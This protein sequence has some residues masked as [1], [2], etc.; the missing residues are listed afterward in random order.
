MNIQHFFH[1]SRT[2]RESAVTRRTIAFDDGVSRAR[3]WVVA[4]LLCLQFLAGCG[5]GSSSNGGDSTRPLFS[6]PPPP[7][8]VPTD[9]WQGGYYRGEATFADGQY[10]V[11]AIVTQQGELRMIVGSASDPAG[12]AQFVGWYQTSGDQADGEGVIIGQGCAGPNPSP[13]CGLAVPAVLELTEPASSLK[14]GQRPSLTGS[15]EVMADGG[16]VDWS[17][18]LE[19]VFH[20]G[21]TM[22]FPTLENVIDVF[23]ADLYTDAPAGF[24]Q[25]IVVNIDVF[26][27]LFF[28]S[29]ETGCVGNGTIAPYSAAEARLFRVTLLV[30]NCSGD[31]AYLNGPMDGLAQYWNTGWGSKDLEIY[32]TRS[33]GGEGSAALNAWWWAPD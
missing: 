3:S 26:G 8:K 18:D 27:Q 33:G 21:G 16:V 2:G 29:A 30:E 20:N 10:P 14:Y 9:P 17:L 11:T 31:S 7:P 5:A 4:G 25:D 23:W 6:S 22:E 32:V 1:T 28:Q 24:G 15:L 13:F 19:L 12:S